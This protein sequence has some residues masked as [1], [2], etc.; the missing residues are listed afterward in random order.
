MPWPSQIRVKET[1]RYATTFLP[2]DA[3]LMR[4]AVIVCQS[5]RHN[6]VFHQTSNHSRLTMSQFYILLALMYWNEVKD[7]TLIKK[8]QL[9]WIKSSWARVGSTWDWGYRGYVTDEVLIFSHQHGSELV[10][11]SVIFIGNDML[12]Q[13]FRGSNTHVTSSLRYVTRWTF[14]LKF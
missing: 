14:W 13:Q 10:A 2:R 8:S 12:L 9:C 1:C 11:G 6:S 7:E 5:V 4:Y 3:M